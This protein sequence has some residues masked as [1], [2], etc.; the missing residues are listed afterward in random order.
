[1]KRLVLLSKGSTFKESAA[2]SNPLT[3]PSPSVGTLKIKFV[4]CEFLNHIQENTQSNKKTRENVWTDMLLNMAHEK[5][6]ISQK[7]L[8]HCLLPMHLPPTMAKYRFV[9]DIIMVDSQLSQVLMGSSNPTV[10]LT[11][12]VKLNIT[13]WTPKVIFLDKR[14]VGMKACQKGKEQDKR[15]WGWAGGG[16]KAIRTHYACAWNCQV[17]K[18]IKYRKNTGDLIYRA[19]SWFDFSLAI[20]FQTFGFHHDNCLL[21]KPLTSW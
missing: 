16:E 9:T 3:L 20:A 10:T 17:K 7:Y 5:G 13:K 4:V 21:L 19:L 11:A 18:L 14:L 15:G 1:M 12:L 8:S 6:S 2:K